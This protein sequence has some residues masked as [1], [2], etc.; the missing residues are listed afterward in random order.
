MPDKQPGIIQNTFTSPQNI[1][2]AII[3]LGYVG[4]PLAV[5]FA[6]KYQVTGFDV[7]ESRVSE[8]SKGYDRTLEIEADDLNSVL[9]SPSAQKGTKLYIGC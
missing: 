3:G 9:N 5:E 8:L 4:L 6:R 2:I 1:H 7:K